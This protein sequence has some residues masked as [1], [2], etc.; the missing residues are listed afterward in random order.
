M[1]PSYLY[2]LVTLILF[3][4]I[5]LRFVL[6]KNDRTHTYES[7]K[8]S[9]DRGGFSP[10]IFN[11]HV[12]D[13]YKAVFTVLLVVTGTQNN[14]W[15]ILSTDAGNQWCV[16]IVVR[17]C[18]CLKMVTNYLRT[19]IRMKVFLGMVIYA[20][21]VALSIHVPWIRRSAFQHIF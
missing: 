2:S 1:F 10:C 16:Y 15:P 14:V 20:L 7:S 8:L 17:I 13:L 18:A 3:L 4:I 9:L 6:M 12:I 21:T 11:I 19:P 5:I